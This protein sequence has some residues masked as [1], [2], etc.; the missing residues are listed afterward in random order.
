MATLDRRFVNGLFWRMLGLGALTALSL[1]W[2]LGV[3]FAASLALG[4]L[5][6]AVSLRVT[7]FTIERIFRG[8][9]DGSSR[10]AGWGGLL[11][12]KMIGL[13]VA[14]WFSLAVLKANPIGFVLGF[15]MILPALAWQ[16]LV[17]GPSVDPEDDVDHNES[18]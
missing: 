12:V 1:I 10:S 9:L 17:S 18:S 11:M 3:Q 7:A 4:A 16:A 14:V 5:V 13:L 8:I 6:G 2:F 15:K